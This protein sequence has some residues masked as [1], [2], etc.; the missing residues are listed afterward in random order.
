M[1]LRNTPALER[2][3]VGVDFSRPA[4]AAAEWVAR[5]LAPR[6]GDWGIRGHSVN[7]ARSVTGG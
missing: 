3:I 5:D 2:V 7:V 6:G 4:L 1:G